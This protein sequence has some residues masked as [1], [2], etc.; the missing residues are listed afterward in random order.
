MKKRLFQGQLTDF[1]HTHRFNSQRE[2]ILFLSSAK[3]FYLEE[4]RERKSKLDSRVH[5]DSLDNI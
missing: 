3:K 5:S 1:C 2:Q 4:R